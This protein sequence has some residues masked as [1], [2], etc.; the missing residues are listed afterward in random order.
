MPF[1]NGSQPMKFTSGLARAWAARCS[2]PPKP[3]SS[4]VSRCSPPAEANSVAGGWPGVTRKDGRRVWT[5][6]S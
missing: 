5:S 6:S 1:T 3:I 4:Q 2:P